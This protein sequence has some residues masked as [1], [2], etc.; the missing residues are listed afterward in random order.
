M[1]LVYG[2]MGHVLTFEAGY[3]V[4]LVVENRTMFRRMVNDF[5]LQLDGLSG[6][7]V[8]SVEEKPVEIS[9][10]A[11][12]VTQFAPFDI[13]RKSLLTKLCSF[14]ERQAQLPEY[15]MESLQLLDR[16]ELLVERLSEGLSV[17]LQCGKLA[18]GPILRAIG[19]E[20]SE[21]GKGD[22]ERLFDYM[23]LVRDLDRDR[24]FVLV[25]AR[26]FFPDEEMRLFLKT[27]CAH[28]FK[29]LLL[30][31]TAS[32]SLPDLKR[33]VIDEDLCEF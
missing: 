19:I 32:P 8:L 30:E 26:T 17:E 18:I 11:D 20:I 23:N 3:A 9:R 21:E 33:Y 27:V 13:N 16:M 28:D 1:K 6:G 12:M 5:Y 25:N 4:E 7:F 15:Y 14:L 22:L 24:L 31:S 29:L 2:E 10:S